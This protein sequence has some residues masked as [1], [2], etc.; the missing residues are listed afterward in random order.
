MMSFYRVATK[1]DFEKAIADF[2]IPLAVR[3]AIEQ[4]SISMATKLLREFKGIGLYDA[5]KIC[6][7]YDAILRAKADFEQG[8]LV[9][10]DY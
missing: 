7:R 8:S 5:K 10:T 1:S 2:D 9:Y 4:E 3:E 6:L